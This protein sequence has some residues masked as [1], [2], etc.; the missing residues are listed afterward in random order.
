MRWSLE[1]LKQTG[2][3]RMGEK[4]R[5][6]NGSLKLIFEATEDEELFGTELRYVHGRCFIVGEEK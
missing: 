6:L 4:S 2:S 5:E 3:E 1:H